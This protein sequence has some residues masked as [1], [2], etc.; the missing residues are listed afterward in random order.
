MLSGLKH[1]LYCQ[2]AKFMQI[3]KI[4]AGYTLIILKLYTLIILNFIDQL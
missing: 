3:Y 2:R 4:Y 1:S